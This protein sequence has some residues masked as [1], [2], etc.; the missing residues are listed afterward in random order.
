MNNVVKRLAGYYGLLQI[1]HISS[2]A[3]GG[4]VILRSGR[5]T[6]LAQPPLEGWSP[7]VIPFLLGLGIADAFAAGLGI[8]FSYQ[9]VVKNT[10]ESRLGLVSTS[11]ALASALTFLVGTLSSGAWAQHPFEYL[12]MV[13]LFSPIPFLFLILLRE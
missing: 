4:Y 2:L 13:V 7:Q 8:Y 10:I 6:F 9:A 11:I 12:S 1:V 3:Y 5:M